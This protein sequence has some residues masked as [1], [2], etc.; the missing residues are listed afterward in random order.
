MLEEHF[1]VKKSGLEE[2]KIQF[3]HGCSISKMQYEK[4]K[5]K[6]RLQFD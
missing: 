4:A 1:E 5:N 6:M 2:G 3:F